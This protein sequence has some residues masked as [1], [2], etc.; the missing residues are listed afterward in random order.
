MNV[1]F[2][3]GDNITSFKSFIFNISSGKVDKGVSSVYQ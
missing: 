2:L 1:S 3:E